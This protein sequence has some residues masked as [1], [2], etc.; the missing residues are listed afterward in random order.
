MYIL[1]T[2]PY[3]KKWAIIFASKLSNNRQKPTIQWAQVQFFWHWARFDFLGPILNIS[4]TE[5]HGKQKNSMC[6]QYTKAHCNLFSVALAM[7]S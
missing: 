5:I 7:L 4:N 3:L 1:Y 2:V 6:A